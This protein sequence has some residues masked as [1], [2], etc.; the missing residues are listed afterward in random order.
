MPF[1]QLN[2]PTGPLKT[3]YS[4]STPRRHDAQSIIP[5]LPTILFLHPIYIAQQ[6]F[7]AQ[8]SDYD[9]RQFNLVALDMRSHGESVGIIGESNKY[10][11]VE[12][13]I[14]FMNALQLNACHIF[15]LSIASSVALDMAIAYPNRVLSVT[16]CSPLSPVDSEDITLGRLQVHEYW[17]RACL[18]PE[19]ITR[20]LM[21]RTDKSAMYNEQFLSD[22]ILGIKQLAFNNELTPLTSAIAELS[23]E[24]ALRHWA[25]TPEGVLEGYRAA[26]MW[27]L[28]R[29]SLRSQDLAKITCPIRIIYCT[30][31]IIYPLE[32]AEALEAQMSSIGL[33]VEL[34][35]VTG[36]HYGCVAGAKEI[37]P[38]VRDLVHSCHISVP[39]V[40]F[41]AEHFSDCLKTPFDDRLEGFNY[42]PEDDHPL[43]SLHNG[44]EKHN[45]QGIEAIMSTYHMIRDVKQHEK[46]YIP[47]GDLHVLVGNTMFRIHS[48]FFERE[49]PI[50]SSR[51]NPASPG[52]EPDGTSDANPLMLDDVKPEEFEKLLWVFYNP[53]YSLYDGASP[54]DWCIILKLAHKWLFT[55]V[56]EL[57][58]RELQK[59]ELEAVR[60]IAVYEQCSVDPKYIVPLYAELCQRDTPL[61]FEESSVLGLKGFHFVAVMR[62]KLRSPPSNGGKSPLPEGLELQDVFR[63]VEEGLSIEVGTTSIPCALPSLPSS[64]SR[65]NVSSNSPRAP[66]LP[67]SKIRANSIRTK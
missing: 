44:F 58:A 14:H 35:T 39:S 26:V 37:N 49:S 47:A 1:V 43:H 57:S 59:T 10:N 34:H 67:L 41:T 24:Q 25:G 8:F 45:I 42:H 30:E 5:E 64:P 33:D 11:P 40:P 13:V 23:I 18:L 28:E 38:I 2:P 66:R 27:P 36:S 9:L 31:D 4:I 48:Y 22:A 50:F 3:F 46:Y 20:E 32:N 6:I 7:E 21:A 52:Q 63:A 54:N 61:T 19:G 56:K 15:G 62:E 17:K 60:K 51:R 12:D 55:E 53:R 16:M 65:S 29:T